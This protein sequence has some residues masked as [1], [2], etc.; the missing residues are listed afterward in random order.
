MI[1]TAD[2]YW[3][4][5]EIERLHDQLRSVLSISSRTRVRR[6]SSPNQIQST[7]FSQ[8]MLPGFTKFVQESLHSDWVPIMPD[9]SPF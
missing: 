1:E 7:A 5:P 4:R 3:D 2:F 9:L 8:E 6:M